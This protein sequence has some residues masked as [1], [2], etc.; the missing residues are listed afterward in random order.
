MPLTRFCLS[1]E[2]KNYE[3]SQLWRYA[4]HDSIVYRKFYM[5]SRHLRHSMIQDFTIKR[6]HLTLSTNTMAINLIISSIPTS[7]KTNIETISRYQIH[8]LPE[9]L[10]MIK[11][12]NMIKRRQRYNH[13]TYTGS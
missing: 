7:M 1:F 5:V 4:I 12:R 11:R 2:E 9:T 13:E 10:K 3:Y 6:L 8:M